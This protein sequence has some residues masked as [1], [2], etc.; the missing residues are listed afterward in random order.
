M[1]KT[2]EQPSRHGLAGDILRAAKAIE[3]NQHQKVVLLA[4]A[5]S[6]EHFNFKG[7]RAL[8]RA[9]MLDRNRVRVVVRQLARKGLAE[10]SSGLFTEDGEV[11][12]SGYAATQ[13]GRTVAAIIN[14]GGC[15]GSA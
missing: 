9:T 3:T 12:G 5:A 11:A 7:F 10:Y 14:E 15:N 2:A 1:K 8:A 4:L 13:M 6:D